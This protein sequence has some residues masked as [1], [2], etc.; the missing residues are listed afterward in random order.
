MAGHAEVCTLLLDARADANRTS[1]GS[2]T[3]LMG[4]AMHG[5]A[6]VVG[7]LCAAGADPRL[8]NDFG[9]DAFD[10]AE[11]KGHAQCKLELLA[12]EK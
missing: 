11:A 2:R 3:P 6:A 8:R 12:A 4:A 9:E 1:G 5:H 7:L 10:L